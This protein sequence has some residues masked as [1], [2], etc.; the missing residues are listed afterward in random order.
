MTW[1]PA[2][3]A[4]WTTNCPVP[5]AAAVTRTVS[6]LLICPATSSP[7]HALCTEMLFP[8]PHTCCCDTSQP[9][10]DFPS[11][12]HPYSE[13]LSPSS[14]PP[15]GVQQHGLYICNSKHEEDETLLPP[16]CIAC[17]EPSRTT[18]VRELNAGGVAR[19][20]QGHLWKLSGLR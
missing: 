6:S 13:P 17:S 2:A 18:W 11:C 9:E 8:R 15:S 4:S 20:W 14:A 5:P 3:F 7:A 19:G 16:L 10:V 1:L 12:N